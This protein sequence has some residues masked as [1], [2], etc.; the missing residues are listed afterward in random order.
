M[1]CPY[2]NPRHNQGRPPACSLCAPH[3]AARPS[4]SVSTARAVL[5][6]RSS[7]L[8]WL[9]THRRVRLRCSSVVQLVTDILLSAAAA[10]PLARSRL[11]PRE[12]F[13]R[14]SAAS[15][16]HRP[17]GLNKS[18]YA[19]RTCVLGRRCHSRGG[20]PWHARGPRPACRVQTWQHQ[21]RRNAKLRETVQGRLAPRG[22]MGAPRLRLVCVVVPVCLDKSV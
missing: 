6:S 18:V 2:L 16:A 22:A 12:N 8:S 9:Q 7:R 5:G 10:W 19:L 11:T 4:S 14:S 13:S 3:P 20:A 15:D 1:T 21:R 17:A